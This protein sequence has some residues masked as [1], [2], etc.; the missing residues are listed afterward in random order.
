MSNDYPVKGPPTI[1]LRTFQAILTAAHSPAAGEAPAIYTAAM[2]YGVDPAVL[3]AIAQH[4]SGYGSKGI[5][6]GRH[7]MFGDRYYA[8]TAAF[9]A[10]NRGGWAAFPTYAA[11]AAYTASLLAAHGGTARSFPSWYAPASDGNKPAAYGLAIVN[12]I[13]RWRGSA[14]AAAGK[15]ASSSSSP[16]KAK[17]KAKAKASTTIAAPAGISTS[18]IYG[19]GTVALVA[20]L[21]LILVRR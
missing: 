20:I 11:G 18:A 8:G 10:V 19:L 7:N 12:N 5:A 16:A 13:N 17:P 14:P 4:E 21:L 6:V 1:D 3:L 2:R 9:G 15:A